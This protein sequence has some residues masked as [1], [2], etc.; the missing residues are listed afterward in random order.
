MSVSV[1]NEIKMNT[2]LSV[3]S[4]W[5]YHLLAHEGTSH[6][7]DVADHQINLSLFHSVS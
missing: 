6:N 5:V 4:V 3:L 7:A 2:V 1:P